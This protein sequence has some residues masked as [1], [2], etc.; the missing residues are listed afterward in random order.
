M[1]QQY[2]SSQ[3]LSASDIRYSD[4][5]TR[6]IRRQKQA[7]QLFSELLEL[8]NR[9]VIQPEITGP[10]HGSQT[11]QSQSVLSQ[12]DIYGETFGNKNIQD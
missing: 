3:D 12:C 1:L 7:T 5:F 8:R 9:L 2:H 11:V 10:V 4:I 6:D